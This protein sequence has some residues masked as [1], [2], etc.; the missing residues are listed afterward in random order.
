MVVNTVGTKG[1]A[2]C[3]S[4]RQDAICGIGDKWRNKLRNDWIGFK[5]KSSHYYAQSMQ[6]LLFV[7]VAFKGVVLVRVSHYSSKK[8]FDNDF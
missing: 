3:G 6:M 8:P 1:N 5:G 7:F 2:P 4:N